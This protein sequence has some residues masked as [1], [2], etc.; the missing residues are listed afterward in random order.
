MKGGLK[1]KLHLLTIPA[2]MSFANFILCNQDNSLP[3]T[4]NTT[5]IK[6]NFSSFMYSRFRKSFVFFPVKSLFILL[7]SVI[8]PYSSRFAAAS[9]L[10]YTLHRKKFQYSLT[11]RRY[12]ILK[13]HNAIIILHN[14]DK[15]E[16]KVCKF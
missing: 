8:S 9:L 14:A 7:V 12:K 15:K 4:N 3:C 2:A 11:W 10:R 6:L 1:C 5:K 16:M 13:E